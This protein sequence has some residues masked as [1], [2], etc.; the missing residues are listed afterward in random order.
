MNDRI[1][2]TLGAI[3]TPVAIH[4]EV[5]AANRRDSHVGMDTGE[6]TLQI[7]DESE[8][9]PRRRVAPIEQR[10]EPDGSRPATSGQL[11]ERDQVPVVRVDTAG[12]DQADHV[13]A[14]TGRSRAVTGREQRGSL[15]ERAVG[16][17]G[18][19]PG[20]VLEHRP[21]GSEIQVPNLGVAHLPG[22]QTDGVGRCPE[23]GVGPGGKE[24]SPVRHV[25]RGDRVRTWI[26]ADPE[27]VEDDQDDRPRAG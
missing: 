9:R 1:V 8:S 26:A 25:R 16:D 17:R 3:P 24:R 19:D 4:P 7:G 11:D 18:V 2:C 27:A 23:R 20:Q 15:E 12:A 21:P 6:S 14:A 13:E 5:A 10:M 22:R